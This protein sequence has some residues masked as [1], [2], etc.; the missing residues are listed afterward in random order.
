MLS[1][2]SKDNEHK[3]D[4]PASSSLFLCFSESLLCIQL[5]SGVAHLLEI[6]GVFPGLV[7]AASMT[8]LISSCHL[9]FKEE[10]LSEDSLDY[11]PKTE[12]D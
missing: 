7:R 1:E 8:L 3:L 6:Q 2:Y 4:F 10:P 5:T 12:P 11:P 9:D